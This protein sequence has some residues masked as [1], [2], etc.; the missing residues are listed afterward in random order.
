MQ[1]KKKVLASLLAVAS[2][3]CSVSATGLPQSDETTEIPRYIEAI[4]IPM[5]AEEGLS[6]YEVGLQ[7]MRALG[8][9]EKVIDTVPFS[10]V[11]KYADVT[12]GIVSTQYIKVSYALPGEE[13]MPLSDDDQEFFV[14]S[15]DE[16][17]QLESYHSIITKEQYEEEAAATKAL[18]ESL[19]NVMPVSEISDDVRVFNGYMTLTATVATISGTTSKYLVSGDYEWTTEP[20]KRYTDIFAIAPDT[21]A[22]FL[23]SS[24][25]VYYSC[26]YRQEVTSVNGSTTVYTG[27]KASDYDTYNDWE[28]KSGGGYGVAVK[29]WKNGTDPFTELPFGGSC[30]YTDFVGYASG[31]MVV[32]EPQ[33]YQN[34][35]IVVGYAQ[36]TKSG[37]ISSVSVSIPPAVGI[38]ISGSSK[39]DIKAC[40]VSFSH[41]NFTVVN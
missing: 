5:L 25:D 6:E 23:N 22:Y 3:I 36:Q 24:L 17:D 16:V 19:A 8:F 35:K 39:H 20:T 26:K 13:I 9:S 11:C 4:N 2:L 28:Y 34:M 29:M 12:S 38:S 31:E 27:T 33:T 15:A 10:E 40:P 14:V 21:G 7:N 37:S 41:P 30:V 32:R 1:M 18:Q